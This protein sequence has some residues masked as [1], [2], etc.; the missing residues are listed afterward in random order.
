MTFPRNHDTLSPQGSH[1]E[2][3]HRSLPPLVHSLSNH[4]VDDTLLSSLITLGRRAPRSYWIFFSRRVTEL[5]PPTE[6]RQGRT[7]VR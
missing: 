6:E 1:R 7:G 3:N 5:H 4:T 2:T